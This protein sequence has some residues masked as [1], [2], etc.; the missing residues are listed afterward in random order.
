MHNGRLCPRRT[1]V[2]TQAS[3]AT[4][5]DGFKET[6][7]GYVPADT[8]QTAE[9]QLVNSRSVR[10]CVCVCVCV[11][12]CMCVRMDSGLGVRGCAGA[13]VSVCLLRLLLLLLPTA[14]RPPVLAR[15]DRPTLV[16]HS[17]SRAPA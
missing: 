6:Q 2:K 3:I 15:L 11:S 1:K 16:L 13:C 10:V 14:N 12:V 4:A 8:A 17:R 5:N 9:T 7:D